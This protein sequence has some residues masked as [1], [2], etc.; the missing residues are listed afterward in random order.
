[1]SLFGGIFRA[2]GKIAKAGLSSITHG[3]SDQVIKVFKG[4]GQV[5]QV[6]AKGPNAPATNNEAATVA[7]LIP[8]HRVAGLGAGAAL[9]SL[10]HRI[11][12]TGLDA[13]NNSSSGSKRVGK[14][15]SRKS[16]ASSKSSMPSRKPK[17]VSGGRRIPSGGLD[18]KEI[19]RMWKAEGKPGTWLNYIKAHTD[20]RKA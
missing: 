20:V 7:K 5:K 6:F 17:R 12:A 9:N 15:S 1:M 4:R 14:G 10:A 3:A 11:T 13:Y 2:V 16:K 19:S 8:S 18:L